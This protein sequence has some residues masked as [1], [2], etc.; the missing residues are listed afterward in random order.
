MERFILIDEDPQIDFVL[1]ED[2]IPMEFDSKEAAIAYAKEN[3]DV[4]G[5]ILLD[6]NRLTAERID[7]GTGRT[8]NETGG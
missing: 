5:L 7:D 6:M 1:D 2:G 4:A 8:E 3:C